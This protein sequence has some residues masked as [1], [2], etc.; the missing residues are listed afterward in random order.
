MDALANTYTVKVVSLWKQLEEM[1]KRKD[2]ASGDVKDAY[3]VVM[4]DLMWQISKLTYSFVNEMLT[5][6][7]ELFTEEEVRAE[8]AR[9]MARFPKQE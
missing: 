6:E 7:D 9:M 2:D 4:K 5:V 1:K 8:I 3:V